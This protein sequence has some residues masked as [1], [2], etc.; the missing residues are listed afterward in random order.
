MGTIRAFAGYDD[1]VPMPPGGIQFGRYAKSTY[2]SDYLTDMDLQ[3]A[4]LSPPAMGSWLDDLLGG[5]GA[6]A[7]DTVNATLAAQVPAIVAATVSSP[8]FQNEVAKVRT[9]AILGGL[10]LAGIILGGVYLM[11]GKRG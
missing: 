5:A 10:A 1:S 7:Q 4:P 2:K 3:T 9:Q 11:Q 6:V 8:A